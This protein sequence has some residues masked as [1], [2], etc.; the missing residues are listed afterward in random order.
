MELIDIK[1]IDT[2]PFQHRKHM[3]P[4]KLREL[5]ES[6]MREGLIE[7]VVL[8]RCNGRFQLIC[9]ERRL[10]AVREYT[11]IKSILSRVI[12]ANDLEARRMCA[13]ENL[14][15]ENLSVIETIETIVD[16]VDS[17]LC[18]DELY[19]NMGASAILR[20]KNL[21][22]KLDSIRSSMERGSKLS[23]ANMLFHKF[24]EQVENIFNN[25]PKPLKWRSFY[26]NDLSVLLDTS[27]DV[28][29]TAID[30]NLNRSQVKALE[31]LKR[32]SFDEFKRVTGKGQ[33]SSASVGELSANEIKGITEKAIKRMRLAPPSEMASAVL[34]KD[35]AC[36]KMGMLGIPVERIASLLDLNRKTVMNHIQKGEIA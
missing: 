23:D 32:A 3:S 36:L 28:L 17:G 30:H 5:A 14:Q 13:A 20:V 27:E 21:L 7:P 24:M 9:G 26:E 6:I 18:G 25:L 2:S 29:V 8:R 34:S 35:I 33:G 31:G 22:S 19:D 12:K 4:D 1:K 16:L 10:R 11:D 15:R